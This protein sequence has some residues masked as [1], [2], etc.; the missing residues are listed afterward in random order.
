MI[1]TICLLIGSAVL[2]SG[3]DALV[4]G[5]LHGRSWMLVSGAVSLIAYGVLVNQSKIDFGR[6][7]GGYIVA[8]FVVSQIISASFFHQAPQTRT[9]LGGLLII[10]GGIV[11]LP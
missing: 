6:L 10:A 2:E 5:G 7:M 4:R 11:L 3:G 1:A 8:F 9:L